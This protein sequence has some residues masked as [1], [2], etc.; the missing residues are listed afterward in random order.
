[1]KKFAK[2][3]DIKVG[4][5]GYGGAFNM[6]KAHLDEMVR[7]GMKP[8]AVCEIDESRLAV[9]A[10][11]FPGIETYTKVEDMLKKSDVNLV[12]IITPHNTHAALAM[13]C[14]KA[15]RNVVAEKPLAVTT[16]ECDAMIAAAKKSK[17][18]LSTYHN[19]HWDSII[20]GA[21]KH[22]KAGAIGEIVR[23]DIDWAGWG[24]P[25][26]WWRS[27]KS[28][29]GGIL[30]DWGVHLLEYTLQM[31]RSDITEVTGYSWSGVWASQ[32]KWKKD[33][34]EDEGFLV[35]RFKS[36]A[37]ST[38][39]FSSIEEKPYQVFKVLGTK[40]SMA[41]DFG[42]T[43]I[44]T[45]QG[46]DKVTTRIPNPGSEGWKFYQNIADHLTKGTALVITP[47]WSRRPIHILDLACQ[48]AKAGR[49]MKSTYK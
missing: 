35:V 8:A 40:G 12:T 46:D 45:H 16:A 1:M 2:A 48:S 19:R 31:V 25:G 32:T 7:A 10:K 49:A 24:K 23:V 14:L 38:L 37:W 43:E 13:K 36:G 11:D 28:I 41:L 26:D 20:L 22:L 6:G 29:S 4:V 39:R 9:A 47:E 3:A 27:S 33:T 34:N 44:T 18:V 15:G 5:V 21:M 42:A 17:A 30:Y